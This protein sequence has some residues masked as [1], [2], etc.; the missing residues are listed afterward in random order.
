[1]KI[2]IVSNKVPYPANDGGAIATLNLAKGFVKQGSEVTIFSMNTKKHYCDIDSIDEDLKKE[3]KFFLV[4]V[5][6]K[7]TATGA[8]KNFIFSDL[9]Y[10]AQR[11]INKDFSKK[12]I[13]H[14][15]NTKYDIIQLEGLYLLPY[16]EEIKKVSKALISY[17]AHN[18]E[19]EIWERVLAQEMSKSKKIY[20][21]NL[22]KRLSIFEKNLLNSYDVLIPI[23]ERD[24]QKLNILGNKK[25]SF[26]SK[27]GI[28]FTKLKFNDNNIEFPSVF[29]L[30]ALDWIPNQE[31][32]KWFYNK[33]WNNVIDKIPNIKIYIAGRN[34]PKNFEK[35]ITNQKN[36]IYLGEIKD[37]NK[38]INSKAIMIVPLLSGSGIRIKIIEGLSLGK[39]IV[40]T[41]IGSEG[42]PIKNEENIII[43]DGSKKFTKSLID[44]CND[45]KKFSAIKENAI[46]FSKNNFDNN[47]I[48]S[49]LLKFY[50]ENINKKLEK[51]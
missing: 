1:M 33:V 49:D 28:D 22:V 25:P 51:E 46:A 9:P 29:H 17:R 20:L 48:T 24:E 3:I 40:S 50:T 32:L 31:G 47:K 14:L 5:P 45:Y 39:V 4:D 42:I 41:S 43:A 16:V 44:I 30:G 2:L 34:A 35:Y 6:A 12:L 13:L 18:L 10:N 21:K 19:H 15:S 8:F 37:A 11:F 26:V 23:T 38:F 36:T 7:I 27:T